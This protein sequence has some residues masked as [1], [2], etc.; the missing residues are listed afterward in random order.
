MDYYKTL[1]ITKDASEREI[2]KAYRKLALKYHPDKTKGDK[3][4]EKKF[5]EVSEAYAVLSDVEKRRQYDTY[6]SANF[7]QRY[8]QEDIFRGFDLNDILRQFGF[9]QRAQAAS[10]FQSGMGGSYGSNPFG[11]FFRQSGPTGCGGG[12]CQSAPEK[13][14]DMTYQIKVTLE[15]VLN[16]AER[17]ISFRKNG[18]PQ[19]VSVKI[20]KGIEAGKKLRLQGKGGASRNGGPPG[21]LYL[22]IDIVSDGKFSRDGDDLI[23]NRLISYSEACLGAKVEVESLEGKKFMVKVAPGTTHDAKLRIKGYGLPSGPMGE[24]GDLYVRIGVKVPKNLSEEQK[25]VI[26]QL[27]MCGL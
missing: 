4:L 10:G 8:S 17:T 19:N 24:R 22:K 12:G 16:G 6:G 11:S 9:G 26:E 25:K 27:Q 13:G 7:H 21:D 15:E 20:P 1:G 2:K 5:K 18:T 23:V 3:E 14:Q